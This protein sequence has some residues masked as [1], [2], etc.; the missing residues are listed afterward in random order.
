MIGRLITAYRKR[1]RL[2]QS[3][4]NGLQQL[5]ATGKT[6]ESAYLDMRELFVLTSGKS[7]DVVSNK[8]S[9][10]KYQNVNWQNGILNLKSK[11]Q[12]DNAL[13]GIKRD[14][15]FV[16]DA[17]LSEDAVNKIVEYAKTTPCKYRK[18]AETNAN[19]D[20]KID[21]VNVEE[22]FNESHIQSPLYQFSMDKIIGCKEIQNLV[23]DTSLLAFAQEY[24]N[25][26]PIVDLLAMWW[27]VPFAGRG[28]AEAAQMYHFDLDRLKFVK[29]FFYLT[30]VDSETG[31]HCYV[32]GSHKELHPTLKRDGRFNDDEVEAAFG[33]QNMVELGGKKG[34]IMVVDTRGLHKGKDLTK[35]KRLIFQIEFA[36][37]MFGQTYPP[38]KKP[39]FN[40]Q[41]EATYSKYEYTY[42][43]IMNK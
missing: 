30:D 1:K 19:G 31:P 20:Y 12:F 37:S 14:G 24:L 5:K 3:I 43:Q 18:I 2:Y 22:I 9:Q 35:D 23:F 25:T 39:A 41:D 11:Q 26:K 17:K 21:V 16:F 6:P 4:D 29:F 34:T 27:S 8:I 13:A 10:P 28:K 38:F 32:R 15:Y 42:S 36:N 33:K 40:A 7:N